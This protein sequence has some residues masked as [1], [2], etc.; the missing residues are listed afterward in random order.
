ML[1]KRLLKSVDE[2]IAIARGEVDPS[3][4]RVRVPADVDVQAIRKRKGMSQPA[5]AARY[6]IPLATLRDWEQ[7]RR[8]PEGCARTLLK[9]IDKNAKAVEDVLADA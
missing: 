7:H 6:Q 1:G 8:T 9:L 2:A 3:T 5:F 4:Y